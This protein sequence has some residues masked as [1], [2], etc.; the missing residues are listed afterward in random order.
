[1]AG[2]VLDKYLHRIGLGPVE[3]DLEGLAAIQLAHMRS[4][5]FENMDVV[6]KKPIS[7]DIGDLERKL[8][9]G[10]RGGNSW[11]SI[12]CLVSQF[13]DSRLLF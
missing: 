10:K 5:S 2:F 6:V 9:D 13:V 12:V 11:P 7:M 1:M 3:P 8:V 4:I